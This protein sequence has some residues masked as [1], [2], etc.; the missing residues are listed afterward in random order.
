MGSVQSCIQGQI[1]QMALECKWNA[2]IDP[3][4]DRWSSGILITELFRVT[5]DGNLL[6]SGLEN[7]PDRYRYVI[8]LLE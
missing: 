3:G 4:P 1:R 8:L 7:L 5:A 2:R 6:T